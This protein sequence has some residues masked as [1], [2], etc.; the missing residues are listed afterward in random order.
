MQ[1]TPLTQA[2]MEELREIGGEPDGDPP[3]SR[4]DYIGGLIFF[5]GVY[6]RPEF[7]VGEWAVRLGS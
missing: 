7:D 2:E 5:G 4:R 1:L 3:Y 6:Q